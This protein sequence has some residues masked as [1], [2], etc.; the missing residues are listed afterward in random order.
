VRTVKVA[1]VSLL[2]L[3]VV[4]ALFTPGCFSRRYPRLMETHLEVL[5][6]YASKLV[7]LAQDE[8]TVAAQD[9]G[10]FTYPLER[11][12]DFA[13]VATAHYPDRASLKSFETV[14]A[15]YA[16]LVSDPAILSGAD[17]ASTV[18]ARQATFATAV[19]RTRED[20]ARESAG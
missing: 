16:A 8:R 20:L 18:A 7:A 9:W 1:R 14:V 2:F 13:R 17:A 12:Q 10:E 19:A 11:A 3:V 6:L 5:S 4:A 15:G